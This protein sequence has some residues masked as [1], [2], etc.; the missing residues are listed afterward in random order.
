MTFQRNLLVVSYLSHT[1]WALSDE[2]RSWVVTQ[3]ALFNPAYLDVSVFFLA[4]GDNFTE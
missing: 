2:Q 4:K 1:G 3:L